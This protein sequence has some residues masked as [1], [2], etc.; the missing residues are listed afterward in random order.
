MIVAFSKATGIWL[1]IVVA[2]IF[3]GVMR[4][5]MFTPIL[6]SQFSLPLSGI[7]L[8]LLIFIISYF[9]VPFIGR[10]RGQV[11]VL[12]GLL[13]VVLT[14][15]FEY[16]FGYFVSGKSLPEINEVFNL[17]DGNLFAVAVISSAVAPWLVAKVRGM[18]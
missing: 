17:A 16:S 15:S 10:H 18:L 3:N 12:V 6:G 11:F 8:S 2:A 9:L 13:W 5:K 14:L 7:T 1:I 4:E